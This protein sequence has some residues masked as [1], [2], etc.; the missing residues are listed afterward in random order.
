MNKEPA[1][2]WRRQLRPSRNSLTPSYESFL[3]LAHGD[4]IDWEQPLFRGSVP[5]IPA[6][7]AAA[8]QLAG[9]AVD[10]FTIDVPIATVPITGAGRRD[11]SPRVDSG[12]RCP[13]WLPRRAR[14]N[15]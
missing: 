11:I 6:L 10:L 5:D 13:T 15:A 4:A 3:R 2:I 7:L 9:S 12:S 1:R 8:R 14:R